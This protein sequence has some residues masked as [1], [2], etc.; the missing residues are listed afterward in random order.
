M[1]IG[2]GHCPA[3]RG[4]STD[5]NHERRAGRRDSQR[6]RRGATRPFVVEAALVVCVLAVFVAYVAPT[7]DRPLLEKHAW[8][9][10]QT[11]FTARVFHERGIDL[12]H[13]S[14]PVFG[15]PFE[16]PFESPLFQ[17]TA[18]V[19]MDADVEEDVAMR[20]P[21]TSAPSLARWLAPTPPS[22]QRRRGMR[23]TRSSRATKEL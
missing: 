17:A 13:P 10:T 15:E 19:A 9:Q 2:R 21:P 8:R 12:L 14:L 20:G 4:R 5:S 7:L 6:L 22:A 23:P 3:E 1:F 11:A 18:S 16:V